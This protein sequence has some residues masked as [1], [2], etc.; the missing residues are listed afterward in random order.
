MGDHLMAFNKTIAVLLVWLCLAGC[1]SCRTQPFQVGDMPFNAQTLTL[2]VGQK[3][4]LTTDVNVDGKPDLL[5]VNEA[6]HSL[7][8]FYG[9]GKGGLQRAIEMPAGANP[10]SLA[11]ADVNGDGKPDVVIANHETDYIS[12]LLAQAGGG[13]SR[14]KQV[15][16]EVN[17]HPHAVHL[18]DINGDSH[19]DLLVD[20]RDHHG[21]LLL[22]GKGDGSFVSPGINIKV[23]GDPY[24]G[25]A[26]GDINGDNALDIVTPNER[27]LGIAS[28]LLPRAC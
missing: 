25:F 21:V 11:A 19:P 7:L 24:L 28:N 4:L 6:K 26:I 27:A 2:G 15:K 5:V 13:F 17:P 8:V 23:G 18:A 22:A 16:L 10:T 3:A 14:P 20:N 1:V 12:V 9:D